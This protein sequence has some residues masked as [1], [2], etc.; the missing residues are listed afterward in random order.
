M[1]IADKVDDDDR[2]NIHLLRTLG[3]NQCDVNLHTSFT[4]HA[5]EV[6]AIHRHVVHKVGDWCSGR[7]WNLPKFT[8]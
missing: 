4:H 2:E 3:D 5:Y 7:F 1:K 6:S 8:K